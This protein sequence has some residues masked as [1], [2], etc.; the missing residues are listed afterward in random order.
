M[1]PDVQKDETACCEEFLRASRKSRGNPA[2]DQAFAKI[3]PLVRRTA[4][5]SV[6]R[7]ST[8][9]DW[10]LEK[11]DIIQEVLIRLTTNPPSGETGRSAR[12]TVLG[13]I[14]IVTRNLLVDQY[15]HS[16][17]KHPGGN[18]VIRQKRGV[19]LDIFSSGP[20]QDG[21]K[22]ISRAEDRQ[23]IE[24]IRT[25]LEKEYP[26]GARYVEAMSDNPH[27]TGNEL[28]NLMGISRANYDQ[29]A[30]RTRQVVRNWRDSSSMEKK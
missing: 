25:Y 22:L 23:V 26:N 16:T 30:R 15:K 29:I 24:E 13:W 19:D 9:H 8:I 11:E 17:A 10:A 28:A 21:K 4:A 1:Q 5:R 3:D 27:A 20:E 14:K 12:R 18:K 6:S 2:Y 7:W